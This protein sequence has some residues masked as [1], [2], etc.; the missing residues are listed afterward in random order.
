MHVPTGDFRLRVEI[1]FASV[2]V[3]VPLN[4]DDPLTAAKAMAARE[5]QITET[6]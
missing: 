5:I 1:P 6:K 3:Q 2:T 4:A